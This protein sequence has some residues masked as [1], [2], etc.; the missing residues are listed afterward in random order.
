MCLTQTFRFNI[1]NENDAELVVMDE[2]MGR[3]DSLGSAR[4]SFARVSTRKAGA[5]MS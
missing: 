1:I 3:D 5:Y 4:V 2:D